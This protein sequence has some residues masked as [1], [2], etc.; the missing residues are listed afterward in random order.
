MEIRYKFAAGD[1]ISNESITG[2]AGS[3]FEKGYM[4]IDGLRLQRIEFF[5]SAVCFQDIPITSKKA[6][7]EKDIILEGLKG[8]KIYG[9]SR[10]HT[11]ILYVTRTSGHTHRQ[12]TLKQ[13][14]Y[15]VINTPIHS[16]R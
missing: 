5:K 6:V 7:A 2:W 13:N 11:K 12:T 8:F 9:R 14:A 15:C 1:S 4:S 16:R 3:I 10:Y